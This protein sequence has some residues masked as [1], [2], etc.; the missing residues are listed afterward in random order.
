M[1]EDAGRRPATVDEARSML[2][3]VKPEVS[4]RDLLK[5]DVA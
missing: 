3:L 5:G 1:C 4:R 2:G